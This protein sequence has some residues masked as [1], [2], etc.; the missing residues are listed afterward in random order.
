MAGRI[1]FTTGKLLCELS[2]EFNYNQNLQSWCFDARPNYVRLQIKL[3]YKN[4]FR[5]NLAP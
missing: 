5:K 4:L 2:P 3:V 1:S